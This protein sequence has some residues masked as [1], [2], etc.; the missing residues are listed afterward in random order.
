MDSVGGEGAGGGGGGSHQTTGTDTA[1]SHD[2]CA[3]III[4]VYIIY[5]MQ[6]YI[7]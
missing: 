2:Q 7:I 4:A 6:T 3:V 1:C 5:M